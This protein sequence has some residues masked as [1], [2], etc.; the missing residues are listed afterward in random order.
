MARTPESGFPP[1][2]RRNLSFVRDQV[3]N[4]SYPDS[5]VSWD[6]V[7]CRGRTIG[8]ILMLTDKFGDFAS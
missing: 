2:S 1:T 5:V 6:E 7:Y 3:G 8:L 4:W